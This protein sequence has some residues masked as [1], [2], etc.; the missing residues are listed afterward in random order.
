MSATYCIQI[1]VILCF[2][3]MSSGYAQ[4][5]RLHTDN[6]YEEHNFSKPYLVAQAQL[7]A[8]YPKFDAAMFALDHVLD[9]HNYIQTH[10]ATAWQSFCHSLPPPDQTTNNHT[11]DI[12]YQFVYNEAAVTCILM[13]QRNYTYH[14][15]R[16]QHLVKAIKYD[17]ASGRHIRLGD[18]IEAT[19]KNRQ[20]LLDLFRKA[21]PSKGQDRITDQSLDDCL[22]DANYLY[23]PL[24]INHPST[25]TDGGSP[26]KNLLRIPLSDFRHLIRQDDEGLGA[27]IW[28]N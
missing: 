14:D 9:L 4:K 18:L 15:R 24:Y 26:I 17:L 20:F 25:L 13:T 11:C 6:L 8:R 7:T 10:Y 19:P 22:F 27:L 28:L 1:I 23:L 16:V 3:L 12:S 5:L 2:G 21:Y